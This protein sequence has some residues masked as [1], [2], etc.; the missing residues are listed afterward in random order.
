[1]RRNP[2]L[3]ESVLEI[4][5]V[6]YGITRGNLEETCEKAIDKFRKLIFEKEVVLAV[7]QSFEELIKGVADLKNLKFAVRSSAVG[8]D[9]YDASSAGQNDTF[10]GLRN[11]D[12]ILESI[13]LCWAS[14]FTYQSVEYRCQHIQPID[15]QMSVVVQIM[16]PSDCA[17]VIFTRHP[18][19]GDPRKILITANYGLGE[20]VVSGAVDPDS[21]IVKRTY[22]N[23]ELIINEKQIGTKT[24]F[25]HMNS[26]NDSMTFTFLQLQLKR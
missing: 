24:H 10:L 14:L 1:M 2:G 15:T 7:S 8:E 16:V 5:N 23:H 21:Y 11:L 12:E 20:S 6:A 9:G 17:G 3:L 19:N 18:T 13:K 22:D 25:L 26:T 4:K